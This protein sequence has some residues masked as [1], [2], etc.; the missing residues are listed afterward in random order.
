MTGDSSIRILVVDDTVTYR[1]ILSEA[2]AALASVRLVGTAASGAIALQ[3]LE[4][5]ATDLV[6]LDVHM[7]ELDGL[8][9]LRRI[10]ERFPQTD[11]VMVSGISDRQADCTIQALEAGAL[12]F[13]HKPEHASLDENRAGLTDSLRPI[14]RLVEKALLS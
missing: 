12:D 4:H 7:P 6:L 5:T 10:R 11:V 8:D 3:K 13:I 14:L 1:K 2:A 9:T